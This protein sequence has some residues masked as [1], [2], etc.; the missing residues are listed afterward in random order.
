MQ[1]VVQ[2]RSDESGEGFEL[3]VD[4]HARERGDGMHAA[5][6]LGP[7]PRDARATSLSTLAVDA[8]GE[9]GTVI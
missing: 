7:D 8:P 6:V 1:P 9:P 5:E 4:G 3:G 2:D